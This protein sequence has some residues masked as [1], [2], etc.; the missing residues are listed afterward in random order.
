[1]F[2][3]IAGIAAALGLGYAY[4]EHTKPLSERLQNG[5]SVLIDPK[6]LA[7][8]NAGNV[9][10]ALSTLFT[11]SVNSGAFVEVKNVTIGNNGTGPTGDKT[12]CVGLVG[13]GVP[14]VFNRVDIVGIRR[15]GK[16]IGQG[17]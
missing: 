12:T 9:D 3:I 8:V 16:S 17:F 10:A 13:P 1:M 14:V 11:N 15:N 6:K 4:H 2:K 7:P 5:D